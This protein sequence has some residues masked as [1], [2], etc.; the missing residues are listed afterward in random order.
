MKKFILPVLIV[1]ALAVGCV[2]QTPISTEH[3]IAIDPEL[4]GLW[5]RIPSEAKGDPAEDLMVILKWS[6]TEYVAQ[7]PRSE[8]GDFYRAYL[9][10]IGGRQVLQAHSLGS[11]WG[12]IHEDGRVIYPIINYRIVEGIL[13]ISTMNPRVVDDNITDSEALREAILA[14]INRQDLFEPPGHFRRAEN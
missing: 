2:H 1:T 11:S 6:E 5:E 4:L 3:T 14:N 9:V 8:K 10:E 12:E 13:A 7:V